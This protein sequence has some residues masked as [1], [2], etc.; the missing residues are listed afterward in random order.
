MERGNIHHIK[1]VIHVG[2]LPERM[3]RA[4]HSGAREQLVAGGIDPKIID[5]DVGRVADEGV[6]G[7]GGGAVLW[8]ETD[9]GCL[10]GGSA[11]SAKGVKPKDVGARAAEALLNE[12]KHGGCVD[13]YMQDQLIIFLALAQGKSTLR[14]GPL[15]LHTK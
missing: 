10:I 7:F 1:G 9:E 15:T 8:A 11:V 3:A 14:S 6:V 5:I 4:M 13:E 12:L 2:G